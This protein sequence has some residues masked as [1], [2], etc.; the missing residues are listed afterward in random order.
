[1][2]RLVLQFQQAEAHR[3]T[4][5]Q[6]TRLNSPVHVGTMWPPGCSYTSASSESNAPI[7]ALE[8]SVLTCNQ[9]TS[10]LSNQLQLPAHCLHTA[11]IETKV[12][13]GGKG[14]GQNQLIALPVDMKCW[15]A[16]F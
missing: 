4:K 9:Y 1:M 5:S 2:H 12:I 15:Y 10:Q 6:M 11:A 7:S 14:S 8:R 16:D 13:L 3:S